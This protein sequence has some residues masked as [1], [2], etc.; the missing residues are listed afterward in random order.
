MAL[1][2][3]LGFGGGVGL[4][5]F[6]FVMTTK[7]NEH[8]LSY[9]LAA[10]AVFGTIFTV[11]MLCVMMPLDLLS[12][13]FL[14][15]G[16][17]DST[18]SAIFEID[19]VRELPIKGTSKHVH[20]ICRQALLAIPGIRDVHD[21]MVSGLMTASTGASWRSAGEKIEVHVLK[22]DSGQFVL[23]CTS[24]PAQKNVLFDYG[25]NFDNVETWKK[26]ATEFMLT[27]LGFNQ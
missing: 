21:D 6:I 11:F 13:L 4:L 8:A 3:T 20:F 18:N 1:V 25:K 7:G 2:S 14:A 9:G 16:S 23:R 10:G 26:K 19:Q 15:R 5:V 27:K 12:R 22:R 17:K 24:K